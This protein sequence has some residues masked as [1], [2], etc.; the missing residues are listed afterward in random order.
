MSLIAKFIRTYGT[1]RFMPTL[2]RY[3]LYILE[4]GMTRMSWMA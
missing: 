4:V 2:P 1:V 3:N